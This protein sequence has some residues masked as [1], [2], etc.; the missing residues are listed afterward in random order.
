MLNSSF[1]KAA[2]VYD[3]MPK[4]NAKTT[5][6]KEK[7]KK[8]K[9]SDAQPTPTVGPVAPSLKMK[10]NTAM[11]MALIAPTPRAGKIFYA[12][13]T[14]LISTCMTLY[15]YAC[16]VSIIACAINSLVLVDLFRWGATTS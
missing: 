8:R 13:L 11:A 1:A 5:P 9:K 6:T 15:Y 12:K 10:Q 14:K 3:D 4:S 16:I 7:D 2:P